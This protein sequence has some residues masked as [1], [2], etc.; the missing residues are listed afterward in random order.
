MTFED[1]L[2]VELRAFVADR[3]EMN[4]ASPRTGSRRRLILT[5]GGI[6][7]AA[8]AAAVLLVSTSGVRTAPAFA[9][10][11]GPDGSVTVTVNDL[12]DAPELQADVRYEQRA[13]GC[14]DASSGVPVG[15]QDASVHALDGLRR[16]DQQPP[17]INVSRA[18]DGSTTF[19]LKPDQFTG[20][21]R[22]TI[23]AST[24]DVDSLTIF[25]GPSAKNPTSACVPAR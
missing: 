22:L 25:F 11:A 19:T 9:V 1:R 5:T 6:M 17:V 4:P 23:T 14:P 12:R 13:T 10:Q 24:A 21:D 16:L 3:S 8:G 20:D 15:E 18:A 2:L 7:A